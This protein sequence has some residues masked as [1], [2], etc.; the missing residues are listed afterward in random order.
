MSG[1]KVYLQA[2]PGWLVYLNRGN[3]FSANMK[4]VGL[5]HTGL[6]RL[7]NEDALAYEAAPGWAV[8]ADGM[9]G[10]MAGEEASQIAVSAVKALYNETPQSPPEEALTEAH[11]RVV[12]HAREKN[13]LGKMGTTLVVWSWQGGKPQFAHVGDSRIYA[14]QD[15]VLKQLSTDHTVAQRMLEEGVISEEEMDTAPNRHVLTQA[16][17]MP[18]MLRPAC[19]VTPATGRLLLCSDGL[20]DLVPHNRLCELLAMDDLTECARELVKAALD[21]G[22][23]DNVTVVLIELD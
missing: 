15:G 23:R 9:G 21:K 12:A 16:V 18:G 14:Y 4:I 5:S 8:L 17:G 10:L 2:R 7:N 11:G 6:V 13:F 1:A 19:G 3:V 22:G 20:S